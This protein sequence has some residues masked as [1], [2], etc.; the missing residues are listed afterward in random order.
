MVLHAG[1]AARA[2]PAAGPWPCGRPGGSTAAAGWPRAMAQAAPAR[3]LA[4]MDH[5]QTAAPELSAQH[6]QAKAQIHILTIHIETF[7]KPTQPQPAVPA[8]HQTGRIHPFHTPLHAPAQLAPQ[9][10]PQRWQLPF[11]IL[12]GSVF[13]DLRGI[14]QG[15]SRTG[16]QRQKVLQRLLLLAPEHIGIDHADK[17]LPCARQRP[18]VVAAEPQRLRIAPDLQSKGPAGHGRLGLRLGNVERQHHTGHRRKARRGQALKQPLDMSA[19]SVAHHRHD[20]R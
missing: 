16:H 6:P 2:L 20:Q 3:P 19:M 9:Q 11:E 14:G 5:R 17:R 13:T 10:I 8:Q 4:R 15:Q 18:V 1:C 12:Q 7:V